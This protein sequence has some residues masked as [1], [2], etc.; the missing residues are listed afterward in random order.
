M[1][2]HERVRYL[3]GGVTNFN[4]SEARKYCFL[5]SLKI[6][7]SII[8]GVKTI[9]KEIGVSRTSFLLRVFGEV[10]KCAD[11]ILKKS[12]KFKVP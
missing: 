3:R 12:A 8:V 10:V 7:Y 5:A 6:P 11:Q 9:A 1:K 2:R 4:Q